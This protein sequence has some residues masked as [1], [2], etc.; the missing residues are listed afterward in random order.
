MNHWKIKLF[1]CRSLWSCPVNKAPKLGEWYWHESHFEP[2]FYGKDERIKLENS[3]SLSK[4]LHFHALWMINV[5]C[6][7]DTKPQP[8]FCCLTSISNQSN[9]NS[10]IIFKVISGKRES[11]LFLK[12]MILTCS[13]KF[14]CSLCSKLKTCLL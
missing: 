12:K 1:E 8:F 3:K 6:W 7:N 2:T 13:K 10:K 9:S 11:T 4:M 5:Q 14:D